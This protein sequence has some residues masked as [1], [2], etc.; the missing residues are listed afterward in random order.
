MDKKVTI[1][2]LIAAVTMQIP[3]I[4][5]ILKQ[6]SFAGLSIDLALFFLVFAFMVLTGIGT[7]F[8]RASAD[9]P[10]M[11]VRFLMVVVAAAVGAC[12]RGVLSNEPVWVFRGAGLCFAALIALVAGFS[13]NRLFYMGLLLC[14]V[15]L[16]LWKT[17]PWLHSIAQWLASSFAGCMLD[18]YKVFYF[19]K[20]NVLGLVSTDFLQNESCSGLS[21]IYPM[22]LLVMAYGCFK[23]YRFFRFFYLLV[24]LLFWAIVAQG[25]WI[26]VEAILQDGQTEK[27]PYNSGTASI[28]V[29]ASV[30]LLTWS[31]DQFFS[32]FSGPSSDNDSDTAGDPKKNDLPKD[33][34]FPGSRVPWIA[35]WSM[36]VGVAFLGGW[37]IYKGQWAPGLNLR[38]SEA[39]T[40][41][42]SLKLESGV[43]GWKIGPAT[44]SPESF[45]PVFRQTPNWNHREWELTPE[46]SREGSMKLRIDGIWIGLPKPDWLW[47]W[48]GWK[49]DLGIS[50]DN[51]SFSFGMKRSIVEEAYVVTKGVRVVGDSTL[52][53]P[54]VQ[55]SLVQESVRPI[56]E[57]QRKEQKELH[58]RWVEAIE[59]QLGFGAA[60]GDSIR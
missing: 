57:K 21:L 26:A 22:V 35:L 55:V 1:A 45:S 34:Y 54:V 11:R 19:A 7:Q 2:L 17:A 52:P 25:A 56:T 33:L 50:D 16:S 44:K 43:E 15:P 31:G 12:L 51:G 37:S 47:R 40:A 48:Y 13:T 53:G 59:K 23:G 20:G 49:T 30:L 8:S 46:Q 38:Q 39:I 4:G 29:F 14:M 9:E 6:I 10:S 24:V 18:I 36:I 41:V 60:I 3:A 58:A 42:E 32:A 28:V 27:V 5:L